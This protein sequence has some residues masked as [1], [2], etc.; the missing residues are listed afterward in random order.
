MTNSLVTSSPVMST[1]IKAS[2]KAVIQPTLGTSTLILANGTL[3]PVLPQSQPIIPTQMVLQ[4]ANNSTIKVS[5]PQ[6]IEN[7]KRTNE[8]N[9]SKIGKNGNMNDGTSSGI[10]KA[11]NSN[12]SKECSIIISSSSSLITSNNST[13]TLSEKDVILSR[14]VAIRPNRCITKTTHVNKVPIPALT[15]S[16]CTS[17]LVPDNSK[18]KA[19]KKNANAKRIGNRPMGRQAL[20]KLRKMVSKRK[21]EIEAESVKNARSTGFIEKVDE[22]LALKNTLTQKNNLNSTLSMTTNF[23]VTTTN[24]SATVALE[25]NQ[26]VQDSQMNCVQSIDNQKSSSSSMQLDGEQY[27]I[28]IILNDIN[29][30]SK[31]NKI[32]FNANSNTPGSICSKS[33][34]NA[35]DKNY[36]E[37][38]LSEKNCSEKNKNSLNSSNNSNTCVADLSTQHPS[39]IQQTGQDNGIKN[40]NMNIEPDSTKLIC[41]INSSAQTYIED[42]QNKLP[43]QNIQI[44]K[45]E[46]NVKLDDNTNF[47]DNHQTIENNHRN[48]NSLNVENVCN[49]N[50][51]I[52]NFDL[53]LG[54]SELSNDIFDS[55]QVPTGCQN[56]ESTSPTAAFLLAFPLVSSLT[57]VKVTEVMD[58]DNPD[59]QRETPTLLQIGTL[60]NNKPTQSPNL[61][62]LDNLSFFSSKDIYN[63][64][65]N[66]FEQH[67]NALTMSTNT[68]VN[69]SSKVTEKSNIST[70]LPKVGKTEEHIKAPN[71]QTIQKGKKSCNIETSKTS[72][73][74]TATDEQ[75]NIAIEKEVDKN[76]NKNHHRIIHQPNANS[77]DISTQKLSVTSNLGSQ[78]IQTTP[79][80]SNHLNDND[81]FSNNKTM[82]NLNKNAKHD[83]FIPIK[84][85]L[86]SG[87]QKNIES[88]K[89]FNSDIVAP[90]DKIVDQNMFH[91]FNVKRDNFVTSITQT[92]TN[93]NVF[94][95]DSRNS[96]LPAAQKNEVQ[97]YVNLLP[98]KQNFILRKNL[99]GQIGSQVA[100]I[101]PLIQNNL[102]NAQL[103]FGDNRNLVPITSQSNFGYNLFSM[104]S[105]IPS[106]LQKNVNYKNLNCSTEDKYSG[107]QKDFNRSFFTS[108]MLPHLKD[109][110]NVESMDVE[111]RMNE[112]SQK[113]IY[114]NQFECRNAIPGTAQKAPD[115][116]FSFNISN[117]VPPPIPKTVESKQLFPNYNMPDTNVNYDL[118][119]IT[120]VNTCVY[121]MNK[122][123]PDPLYTN[124]NNSNYNYYSN[125]E[126]FLNENCFKNTKIDKVIGSIDFEN[127]TDHRKTDYSNTYYHDHNFQKNMVASTKSNNHTEKITYNWMTAPSKNS[128]E[129]TIASC[130]KEDVVHSS[131]NI[132]NNNQTTYFNA[133][134]Y[135]GEINSN[136]GQ[137]TRKNL[138]LPSMNANTNLQ[139]NDMEDNHFTWSPSKIPQYLDPVPNFVSST[140]PTLVG[141]LALGTANYTEQKLESSNKYTNHR[142]VKNKTTSKFNYE[143]QSNLFSVSQLVHQNKEIV[144]SKPTRRRSSGSGSK[145]NAQ[146]NKKASKLNEDQKDIQCFT[147]SP[148]NQS[149][150]K[151]DKTLNCRQ[152]NNNMFCD[153][154]K[155]NPVKTS[156]SNY[157]A[158]ALIGNQGNTDVISKKEHIFNS[159][160]KNMPVPPFMSDNIMP[161][162]T[163]VDVP[164]DNYIQQNQNYQNFS[165]NFTTFPNTS[166]SANTFIPSCSTYLS[167]NTFMPDLGS[168][169]DFQTSNMNLFSNAGISKDNKN[170][171][172]VKSNT[173]DREEKNTH[174][175]QFSSNVGKKVKRKAANE[176]SI[177]P[178]FVD[179]SFLSVPGNINSPLLPDDFHSHST[180]LPP[181]LTQPQL[182]PCKNPIYSTKQ[183]STNSVGP[184]LP[185]PPIPSVT[186]TGVQH[187]EVSPSLNSGG[188]SL[189]NFNLSTIFPEINKVSKI[190]FVTKID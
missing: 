98:Q 124:S 40:H 12:D 15:S 189:T 95:I 152:S 28:P 104:D 57:G 5:K 55:L 17:I 9:K 89:Y 18:T 63:G 14:N 187:P 184:L 113:H 102:Q 175:N 59:S 190:L 39:L 84:G 69:D 61:F 185:L 133:P 181:P 160:V 183:S 176:S 51:Q 35:Y 108:E 77:F 157:T 172:S 80:Q 83:T 48:E 33:T 150:G 138:D 151:S 68:F 66:S 92:S 65:Y 67:L 188:T 53:Q 111:N 162:F 73:S 50:Q 173:N 30:V 7:L 26:S 75:A 128:A 122:K 10:D 180:F 16:F 42:V 36:Q 64:F 79:V 167:T 32:S 119:G 24:I 117:V 85:N 43:T 27:K 107:L 145:G 21:I 6:S 132:L 44:A 154:N 118:N 125:S 100:N 82:E 137:T 46:K 153:L 22:K 3:Y 45:K 155:R 86:H 186:R 148:G 103:S 4:V 115:I 114:N 146:K 116:N 174:N 170:K 13:V 37:T 178:N 121:N 169:H 25:N 147:K 168:G 130:P 20:R 97:T 120:K 126:S 90:I 179:F 91:N 88:N 165:H 144:P 106:C 177:T 109:I 110:N 159:T 70:F 105:S 96:Q 139:R 58:D 23:P 54:N 38:K 62:N 164:Q 87:A 182:Y 8:A 141:D 142:D 2:K 94:N 127:F 76:P 72:S 31:N 99:D 131:H 136:L 41:N 1:S 11:Q 134:L 143:N 166:Y 34:Q 140:L 56:P 81:N 101:Q 171:N 156:S 71:N 129:Q 93:T 49:L 74:T 135:T 52:K 29:K 161:Y 78:N 158:E 163:S 149:H 47:L 60:D 112:A 123:F 19:L